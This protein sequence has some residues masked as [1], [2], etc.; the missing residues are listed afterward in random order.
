METLLQDLRYA[1]RRL[2][3]SR[4]FTLL[5]VLTLALGIGANSAIFSVVNAVLLRPLPFAEPEALDQIHSTRRGGH[6]PLSGPDFMQMRDESRA[7][8]SLA[9]YTFSFP[10]LT[11]EGD[12]VR[13]NGTAVSATFFDVL[14]V[15]PLLGRTF[16]SDENEP[17]RN[18]VAVLSHALWQQRFGGNPGVI[19]RAIQLNGEPYEVVGVMPAGF[20][21]PGER[22]LWTPIEYGPAFRSDAARMGHFLSAIGRRTAGTTTAAGAADIG[23]I[24][25]RIEQAFP[26][27]KAGFSGTAV[28]L[29][30][31]LVGDIE[32][33]LLILLGAVGIVLLIAC[34]NVA[35]LLMARA[36]ARES[37]LVVRT[38]LGAER[39]R[40][41]RQLLTESLLLG[42]LGGAVGLLLSVWGT[43]WLLG[44]QPEGIPRL[45]EVGVDWAVV[46]FTAA[47]SV[48]TGLLFGLFPAW[49]VTRGDLVE[50]IKE[51][52][53]GGLAG[54][55][56]TR[57]RGTLVVLE[58][59]LAVMLLAGAGL[60]IRSFAELSAVELGFRT[61]RSL[62]FDLSLPQ[63]AYPEDA[64]TVA[65]YRTMEE[66]LR[67]LPGVQAV[68]A[69]SA[70]PMSGFY[71]AGPMAVEGHEEP[72]AGEE[73][74]VQVRAV[75]PDLMQALGVPLMRGRGLSA[76]DGPESPPVA[77]LT[78][79]AAQRFFPGEDAVGRRV[80]LSGPNNRQWVEVVGIVGDVRDFDLTQ[81]VQPGIYLPHTQR[82]SR[83]MS[84]VLRTGTDP[85][86]LVPAVR[87]EVQ[88][89]DPDLP[90]F[91]ARTLEQMVG[92]SVSQPR[93]YM[94]L[95][96]IFAATALALSAVGIFG[97]MSYMVAQRTREIGIRM[98]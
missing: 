60:M 5:A 85:M 96:A 13:L 76:A 94:L 22:E 24:A 88:A 38:A 49:Q 61:E 65:F 52:G 33:P 40:L 7:Y 1:A 45:D 28:S 8:A 29:R 66:R 82:P 62:V 26:D 68:G 89:L 10:N 93:F 97:V 11:G 36:A 35:N 4:G 43:E 32:T 54:R 12:P 67:G 6:I 15:R 80:S 53:R 20:H 46:G 72:R 78:E 30:D 75:T 59:A 70:V 34:A 64:Q 91:N 47:V 31:E 3:R 73:N 41:V 92:E 16:A 23:A 9:A 19:G 71:Q 79:A 87:R 86:R 83:Q 69:S 25:G 44:L 2:S 14:G 27:L 37:E 98:A 18:R 21:Y 55:G 42:L 48:L 39:G 51:G 95:L 58:T 81:Q 74:I 50:S 90:I 63:A 17:G 57:M 56:A 77:V 84:L